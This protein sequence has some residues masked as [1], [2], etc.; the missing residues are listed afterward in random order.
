MRSL[1]NRR[2]PPWRRRAQ[3]RK[4]SVTAKRCA[5]ALTLAVA[6]STTR[7]RDDAVLKI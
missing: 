7:E 4:I 2:S 6:S 5:A 3:T 1:N